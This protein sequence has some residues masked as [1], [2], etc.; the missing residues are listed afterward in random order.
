MCWSLRNI[1]CSVSVEGI[2]RDY[3]CIDC[4]KRLQVTFVEKAKEK[5]YNK[6]G[7]DVIVI[8]AWL[9][10]KQISYSS[11]PS[12]SQNRWIVNIFCPVLT[13]SVKFWKFT[14]FSPL[15]IS[16]PLLSDL[17]AFVGYR[18][19]YFI[20]TNRQLNRSPS[21]YKLDAWLLRHTPPGCIGVNKF[22]WEW[23]FT[24][25]WIQK[26]ADPVNCLGTA[27]S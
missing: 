6:N 5:S 9:P 12:A 15:N 2:W 22:H 1:W 17:A 11:L 3:C 24:E 4:F 16:G 19:R 20:S 8:E 18:L 13:S 7:Q 23:W 27:M 14:E 21:A 10:G 25:L 26:F